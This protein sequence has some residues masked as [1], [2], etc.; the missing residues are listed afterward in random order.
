MAWALARRGVQVAVLE[1]ATFPREKVCG[2]FVEPAGLRILKA[3]GCERAFEAPARLPITT[4]RVY[5]GP[6]LAYHGNIPYYEGGHGLPTH[7]YII[8]RY[9]LDAVLLQRAEAASAK[10]FQACAATNVRR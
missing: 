9:E 3:M 5:F 4:N 1:R 7:G 6:R 8:P 2:D 10:V